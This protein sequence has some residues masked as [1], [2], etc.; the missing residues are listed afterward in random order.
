MPL[1]K[2]VGVQNPVGVALPPVPTAAGAP[3]LAPAQ[4]DHVFGD[5]VGTLNTALQTIFGGGANWQTRMRNYNPT[6]ATLWQGLSSVDFGHHG[7]NVPVTS[8]AGVPEPDEHSHMF[9]GYSHRLQ[10]HLC[11]IVC[12][13]FGPTGE[14]RKIG[15]A[16]AAWKRNVLTSFDDL[17]NNLVDQTALNFYIASPN[18]TRQANAATVRHPTLSLASARTYA[19]QTNGP[20]KGR[21]VQVVSRCESLRGTLEGILQ[22]LDGSVKTF[23][24]RTNSWS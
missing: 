6:L 3:R 1:L 7:G 9:G 2:E 5:V 4:G 16:T 8:R 19:N 14:K 17:M 21:V 11:E 12:L 13:G 24:V 22:R 15:G 10:W 20:G 23:N 18:A